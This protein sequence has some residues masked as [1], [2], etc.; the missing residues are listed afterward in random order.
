MLPD[1]CPCDQGPG[2]G[3][4]Y[5]KKSRCCSEIIV[6]EVKVY[7]NPHMNDIAWRGSSPQPCHV[8]IGHRHSVRYALNHAMQARHVPC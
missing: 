6:G 3:N 8:A 7:S 2:E 4:L 1:P 5:Y